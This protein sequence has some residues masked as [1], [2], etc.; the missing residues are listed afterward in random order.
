MRICERCRRCRMAQRKEVFAPPSWHRARLSLSLCSGCWK[1]RRQKIHFVPPPES[2]SHGEQPKKIVSARSPRSFDCADIDTA[3]TSLRRGVSSVSRLNS[4]RVPLRAFTSIFPGAVVAASSV[5]ASPI[6][7]DNIH[8]STA[9][10]VLP[11]FRRNNIS[12]FKV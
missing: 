2:V 9:R 6:F 5:L 3:A 10:G 1:A 11:G 12:P 7:S 4:F 8:Q